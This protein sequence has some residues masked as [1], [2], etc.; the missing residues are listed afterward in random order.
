MTPTGDGESGGVTLLVYG[1]GW[2]LDVP[3]SR[4]LLERPGRPYRYVDV[5]Q[6]A[7][8]TAYVR[9]LQHGRR[10]IPTLVRADGSHTVEPGDTELPDFLGIARG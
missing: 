3:R 8:A 6:D 7:A 9:E 1:S 5:E 4:V 10:W 2:C